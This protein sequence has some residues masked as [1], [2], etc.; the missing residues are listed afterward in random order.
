MVFS[1]KQKIWIVEEG[2]RQ[3]ST[4]V[5]EREFVKPFKV[6]PRKAKDLKPHFFVRMIE[7]FRK[8]SA[9][10]PRKRKVHEKN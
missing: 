2:A 5:I 8:T 9:A 10:I 1:D 7:G 4:V 3:K 6:S